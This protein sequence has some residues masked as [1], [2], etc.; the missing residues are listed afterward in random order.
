MAKTQSFWSQ[1]VGKNWCINGGFDIWQRNTTQ[2]T[3]GYGSDDRWSNNSAGSTKTHSRQTSTDV[4]RALFNSPFYSRTVV[5]SV[6]GAANAVHKLQSVEDVTRLAGKTVTVSF[7]AKADSNKNI[8]IEFFQVFGTGGSPSANVLG[9]GSQLV[10]LTST[11]QYKSITVSI[12]SIVGKTFGTDGIHTT[13]TGF[14]FW[15]D[16]GSDFNARSA[17]LGQQ[18]GTFDI[19]QV[20]LEVGASATPFSLAGGSIAG[21]LALCQRYYEAGTTRFDGSVTNGINESVRVYYK[22]T[23]RINPNITAVNTSAVN[24]NTTVNLLSI[25]T[26][27]FSIYHTPTTTAAAN[28]LDTWIADAEL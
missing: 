21:E 8:A 5:S 23:K 12:P 11:W 14:D 13:R 4:E 26:D 16:A 9:I 20:K 3:T 10:S 1:D 28:F 18:S 22:V 24:M 17:S 7:W 2:T 27:S 19:A 6:A 25:T 15:F